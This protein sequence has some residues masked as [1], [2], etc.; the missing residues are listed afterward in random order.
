MSAAYSVRPAIV[1]PLGACNVVPAT[2]PSAHLSARTRPSGAMR[3]MK[4]LPS[5]SAMP[6]LMLET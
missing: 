1:R 2:A 6:P 4:P 5:L 3:L